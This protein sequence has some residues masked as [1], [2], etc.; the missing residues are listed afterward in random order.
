MMFCGQRGPPISQK[1]SLNTVIINNKPLVIKCIPCTSRSWDRRCCFCTAAY[2]H[3][4]HL[5]GFTPVWMRM[6]LDKLLLLANVFSHVLHLMRCLPL[7]FRPTVL[8]H[9]WT[10]R[11][12]ASKAYL[13]RPALIPFLAATWRGVRFDAL[14]WFTFTEHSFTSSEMIKGE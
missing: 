3:W 5:Y 1:S 13:S 6:W 12:A 9:F 7:I 11:P 14:T 4:L 10:L 2:L 8:V